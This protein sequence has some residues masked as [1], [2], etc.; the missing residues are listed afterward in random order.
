LQDGQDGL[1]SLVSVIGDLQSL[2]LEIMCAVVRVIR[3]KKLLGSGTSYQVDQVESS[4]LVDAAIA[5]CKLQHLDPTIS[6]KTQVCVTLRLSKVAKLLMLLFLFKSLWFHSSMQV[7]LI[8]A[9]HD[10]LA[11]YGLCCAGRDGD[12]EE[13]TFLKFA[14]KHL[15]ALD[16]K[17]KSQFSMF[18]TNFFGTDVFV[19]SNNRYLFVFSILLYRSEWDGRRC[20]PGK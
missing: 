20:S 1:S 8:V 16:V 19:I 9:V 2:L 11:E 13:G 15:M 7:E 14:I 3:S 17:L 12:G 5:F 6:I 18:L 10:L 4:C